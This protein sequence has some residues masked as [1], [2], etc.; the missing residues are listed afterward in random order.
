VVYAFVVGPYLPRRPT[1]KGAVLFDSA[2]GMFAE[3]ALVVLT[4]I[5]YAF[6]ASA[7]APVGGGIGPYFAD[8][9]STALF[10]FL[11]SFGSFITQILVVG[12]AAGLVGW[13][14]LKRLARRAP[15]ASPAPPA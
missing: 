13:W 5:L 2:V 7:R 14:V 15:P 8:V 9:A 1:T 10:A 12:N 6:I 4:A 3:C 11:W